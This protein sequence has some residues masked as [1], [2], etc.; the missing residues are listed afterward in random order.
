MLYQ[1]LGSG[2]GSIPS[3]AFGC[4]VAQ[5]FWQLYV[6]CLAFHTVAYSFLVQCIAGFTVY[7]TEYDT[8][9]LNDDDMT[10]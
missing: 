9:V 5:R 10:H 8:L 6:E 2:S 3:K 7:M 4:S 1:D